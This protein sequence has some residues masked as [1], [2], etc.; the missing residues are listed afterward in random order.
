LDWGFVGF[1]NPAPFALDDF[2]A[3]FMVMQQLG[4]QELDVFFVEGNRGLN[5]SVVPLFRN[6]VGPTR[7]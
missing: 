1:A 2:R 6:F 4:L 7:L 5:S 3:R